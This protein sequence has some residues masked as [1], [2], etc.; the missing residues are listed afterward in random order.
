MGVSTTHRVNLSIWIL[1]YSFSDTYYVW[2]AC[3]VALKHQHWTNSTHI[4]QR[5]WQ[6]NPGHLGGRRVLSPLRHPYSVILKSTINQAKH[7]GFKMELVT[8][9]V[10]FVTF[11]RT[12]IFEKRDRVNFC[13]VTH[14][15]QNCGSWPSDETFLRR[16]LAEMLCGLRPLT[17][18]SHDKTKAAITRCKCLWGYNGNVNGR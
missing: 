14:K 1:I 10:T 16:T 7:S 17:I 5:P 18:Q 15:T 12:A 3:G 6:L 8:L 9:S 2:A 13:F 11:C 4:R